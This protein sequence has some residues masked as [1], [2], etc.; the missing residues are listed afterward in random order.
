MRPATP[1][2][3]LL[4]AACAVLVVL[5]ACSE[6]D[7][8]RLLLVGAPPQPKDRPIE[9]TARGYVSSDACQACHAEKYDSW[10]ASYHRTMTQV[11]SPETVLAPFDDVEL[12]H[13][14]ELFRLERRGDEF[15]VELDDPDWVPVEGGRPP[16]VWRQVVM[17]T[18]SHNFQAYWFA[19]GQTRKLS[20]LLFCYR[21]DSGEWIPVDSAF[22]ADP[23]LHRKTGKGRWNVGC[24]QCHATKGQARVHGPDDM[25]TRATEFGIACEACH[26]PG[27]EHVLANQDPVRRYRHHFTG[28]PDPTIVNPVDLDPRLSSQA[29][30]QCHGATEL[31]NERQTISWNKRGFSYVPGGELTEQRRIVEEDEKLFWSDGMIRVSGREYNG[32]IRSPCYQHDD[33]DRIMSCF[34]CHQMH[35]S[36]DDPRSLEEWRV[37]MLKPG[38]EGNLGCTQCHEAYASDEKLAEHSR[39]TPGLPGSTCYDCH[40]PHTTWGLLKGIRSHEVDS[41]SVATSL[42]TGRPS[43]CNLCHLDRPLGWTADRLNE[44]YGQ[45]V[46]ELNDDARSIAASIVWLLSGDAGQRAV[47]SWN[48]GWSLAMATS[49]GDWMAPYLSQLLVDPYDAVRFRAYRSLASIEGFEDLEYDFVG[50]SEEREEAR[51]LAME[52]WKATMREGNQANRGAVLLDAAGALDLETFERLLRARDDRSMVLAE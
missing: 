45:P 32:L 34:S 49:G 31:K 2:R 39:H 7:R 25:N 27:E 19:S 40:M 8:P 38:M 41:P 12:E 24:Q 5:A 51:R 3:T 9:V 44:W 23:I 26:G 30:G 28:D 4:G 15:W 52:R 13:E 6:L 10:Y 48:M 33:A 50:T 29:C 43:A 11:V 21:V 46:P 22:L 42:E 18:G 14:G 20:L 47:L 1:A 35:K 17:S 37:D 16:R 36:P